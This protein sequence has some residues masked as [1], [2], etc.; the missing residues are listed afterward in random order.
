VRDPDDQADVRH[1]PGVTTC[2]LILVVALPALFLSG[3]MGGPSK[4]TLNYE[5]AA[6]RTKAA[7]IRALSNRWRLGGDH[8]RRASWDFTAY[9]K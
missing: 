8:A 6:V 5:R 9:G 3:S 1:C 2:R 7:A 4:A